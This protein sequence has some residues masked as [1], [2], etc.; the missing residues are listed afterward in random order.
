MQKQKGKRTLAVLIGIC[1]VLILCAGLLSYYLV[2]STLDNPP[3]FRSR[4]ATAA[5]RRAQLTWR[6]GQ[7]ISALGQYAT[8]ASRVA[9]SS[10]RLFL[11]DLY[12]RRASALYDSEDY[13]A[14]FEACETAVEFMGY[15]E[16]EVGIGTACPGMAT[17]AYL[18]SHAASP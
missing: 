9:D 12:F 16:V 15:Y 6:G 3:Q 10:V 5:F 8:A 7:K 13:A 1:V 17:K 4:L 14:A 18:Q 11:G 2:S